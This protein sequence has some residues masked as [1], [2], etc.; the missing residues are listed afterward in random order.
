MTMENTTDTKLPAIPPLPEP[1]GSARTHPWRLPFWK[2]KEARKEAKQRYE[3][4]GLHKEWERENY[5]L[6][7]G[8]PMDDPIAYGSH[9]RFRRPN[10]AGERLP[11]KNV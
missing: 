5:R 8:I 1:I 7:H 10:A 2:L 9:R 4:G 3:R 6:K 11:A